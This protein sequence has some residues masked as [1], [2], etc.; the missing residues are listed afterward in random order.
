MSL[1]ALLHNESCYPLPSGV[2]PFAPCHDDPPKL[3]WRSFDGT[4]LPYLMRLPELQSIRSI[5]LI[6]PGTDSVT[7]DYHSITEELLR[8]GHAVYGCE[9]RTF[10]YG[11]GPDYRRGNPM[12]WPTWVKDLRG[13]AH[14]VKARHPGVPVFWHGH[15]FGAVQVLQTAAESSGEDVPNGLIIHSPGFG[16]MFKQA[17]FL[18]GLCYGI[19]A[20]LRVP[21]VRLTET[22]NMPMT[23]DL[24]WDGRWK[25]SKDRLRHG[26]KVRYFIKAADMGIAARNS[27]TQ[28]KMPVLAMWG[29]KDRQGLG[30]DEKLR[31]EYDHYMRHELAGGKA[32]L[33]YRDEGVHL[34]TEGSTKSDALAAII[35]WLDKQTPMVSN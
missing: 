6:V 9:N 1:R 30:G 32:K 13:F 26:I 29:G 34:L 11:P 5:V 19:A 31:A 21:W 16:L 17:T 28:L 2:S 12:D 27:S 24:L 20:W 14:F 18:R 22:G 7:G 8:H 33:F 23:D 25:H 10:R 4:E 15:S 3:I 35:S